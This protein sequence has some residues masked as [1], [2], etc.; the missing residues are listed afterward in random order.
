M[1]GSMEAKTV[2][3]V[4]GGTSDPSTTALLGQRIGDTLLNR[5]AE[6]GDELKLLTIDLRTIAQ[7]ITAAL[8]ERRSRAP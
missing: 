3:V 7:E 1:S 6:R 4:N 5:A 2:V 8:W